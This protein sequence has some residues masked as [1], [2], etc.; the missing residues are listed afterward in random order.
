MRQKPEES[1]GVRG[2]ASSVQSEASGR[3]VHRPGDKDKDRQRPKTRARMNREILASHEGECEVPLGGCAP[4]RAALVAA[5]ST[6]LPR[7]SLCTAQH[8]F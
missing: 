3:A 1:G 2:A 6:L 8:M 7:G 5:C 4:R